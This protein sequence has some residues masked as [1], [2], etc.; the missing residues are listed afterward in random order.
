MNRVEDV[1]DPC[2]VHLECSAYLN[3]LHDGTD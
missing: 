2:V 3:T 1:D